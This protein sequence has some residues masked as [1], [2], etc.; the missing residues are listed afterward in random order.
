MKFSN[1]LYFRNKESLARA[2]NSVA[3]Y[4]DLSAEL[5]ADEIFNNK[6]ADST[7]TEQKEDSE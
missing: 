7:R 6:D 1:G 2:I 5:I 3:C 4:C